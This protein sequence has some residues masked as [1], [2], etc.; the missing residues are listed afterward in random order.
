MNCMRR[1]TVKKKALAILLSLAMVLSL[2]P[3]SAFA[4]GTTSDFSD[5]PSNWSTEALENAVSN[6]LLSGY[7]G[8]IMPNDNLTRAQMATVV[9]RAFGTTEKA[10]ISSYTDVAANAWYYD[11]MAK[12][13]QMKTFIGNGDKLNPAANITREEAFAVLARAFRLSGA[14]QSALDKFSDK[15]LVNSW[16][17]DAAASSIS[18]GYIA[19]S[20]GKLNPKKYIT[21]AEFAQIMDNLLKNYIKTA[22][23]YT[24]DYTGNVMINVPGVTL[25]D[26]KITGDIIIGDGVGNG[27]VTLDGVTVTGRTIIRGGGINS[28]KII[29]NSNLQN[30]IIARVDGQVRVYAED[31]TQIGEVI[32]DGSDNVIIEGNFGA[33]TVAAP[34]ITVTATNA[35]IVDATIDG[36]RSIIIVSDKSTIKTATIEGDNAK[37]ITL[38]GAKIGDIIVNGDGSTISGTGTIGTVEANG[39]NTAVTTPGCLVTATPGSVGNMA[40]T[41]PVTGGTTEIVGGGSS[42]GSHDIAVRAIT[43][44]DVAVTQGSIDFNY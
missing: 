2:F 30:I 21:R 35:D 33:V 37:V 32:V 36:D 41:K 15:V 13:V 9:N 40:G 14:D 6:S 5:M 39:N 3:V 16:A 19:G 20:N 31:G 26:I 18:A 4:S 24:T 44:A 28:I 38:T 8:K 1:I 23:T 22:G 17:K 43:D 42:D 7:N 10:S 29:G 34:D 12:A 27:D 11:D 25:K